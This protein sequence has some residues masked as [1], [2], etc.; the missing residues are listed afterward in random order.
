[1]LSADEWKFVIDNILKARPVSR[2]NLAGGEPLLYSDLDTIID[3]IHKLGIQASVIT[4][5]F[6]LTEKRLDNW[7]GKISTIGISIDGLTEKTILNVGRCTKQGK[8]LN[9]IAYQTLCSS[10]LERGFLLKINTVVSSLNVH[11]NFVDFYKTTCPDRC[12]LLKMQLFQNDKFSNAEYAISDNVFNTFVEIYKS[13]NIENLIV[14]NNLTNSYIIVD[15]SG[16][17]LDNSNNCYKK[18]GNFLTDKADCVLKKWFS[19]NSF[20]KNGIIRY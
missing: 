15:S 13:A 9:R 7:C 20:T 18:R 4:N 14:E 12:K 3:Y 6:L 10:I 16:Y 2:F 11:E 19:M 5:G 1:M 17:L 8:F